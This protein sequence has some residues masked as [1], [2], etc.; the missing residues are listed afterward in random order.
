MVSGKFGAP[1]MAGAQEANAVDFDHD[2]DLDI[3]VISF[4]PRP[5]II[6][7]KASYIFEN[8]G[9]LIY[10]HSKLCQRKTKSGW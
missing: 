7:H 2:G 4:I 1:I 10:I 3:A 6:P 9:G 5:E 8:Q